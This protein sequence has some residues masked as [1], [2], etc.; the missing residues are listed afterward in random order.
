M[1]DPGARTSSTA[2]EWDKI[3]NDQYQAYFYYNNRTQESTWEQPPDYSEP[4]ARPNVGRQSSMRARFSNACSFNSPRF[5]VSNPMARSNPTG[6]QTSDVELTGSPIHHGNSASPPSQPPRQKFRN[7]V[8]T[9]IAVN[10]F[11]QNSQP[12]DLTGGDSSDPNVWAGEE[13]TVETPVARSPTIGPS[14]GHGFQWT[15]SRY[16]RDLAL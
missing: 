8:N 10:R 4:S 13:P 1:V 5:E 6:A 11:A 14:I 15:S 2:S 16:G 3:W 9:V 12:V 7:A